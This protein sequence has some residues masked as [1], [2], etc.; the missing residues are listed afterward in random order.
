MEEQIA[1]RTGGSDKRT[2][3]KPTSKQQHEGNRKP[4]IGKKQPKKPKQIKWHEQHRHWDFGTVDTRKANYYRKY[5]ERQQKRAFFL[6]L[7]ITLHAYSYC[8]RFFTI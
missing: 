4:A 2:T 6:S 5:N 3:E 1:R 7:L 8:H